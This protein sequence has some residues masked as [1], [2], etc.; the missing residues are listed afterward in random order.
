M[1]LRDVVRS[2]LRNLSDEGTGT[3]MCIISRQ[4]L[5]HVG[6]CAPGGLS[7]AGGRRR[8]STPG[9]SESQRQGDLIVVEA[10]WDSD[11]A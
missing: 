2:I 11:L 7:G 9:A 10:E 1:E 6:S 4:L 3:L 8:G 5:P